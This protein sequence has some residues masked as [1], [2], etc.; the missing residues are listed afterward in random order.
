MSPSAP[1]AV[2][3]SGGPDSASSGTARGGLL[4]LLGTGVSAL[5]QLVCVLVVTRGADPANAGSL[6]AGVSVL[7]IG[8]ALAQLG[9]D[10]SLVRQVS[11]CGQRQRR[12]DAVRVTRDA[13][14]AV[15][16]L[17]LVLTASL[18]LLPSTW[19][20][21]VLG[22]ADPTA[23]ALLV[24]AVPVL[25]LHELALAV[26]RGTGSMRPTVVLERVA[27]PLL[28]VVTLSLAVTSTDD[29]R[30]LSV[31]WVLPWVAVLPASAAAAVLHLRRIPD[32]GPVAEATSRR[33]FWRFSA[34]RAV[35]RTCQVALQRADIIIV[36]ALAG[37]P[38]AAVY[39]AATRFM[40]VGQLAGT[41][42]QQAAQPFFARL[43]AAGA[44]E[45]LQ[46][47]LRRTTVWSV[48]VVWPPYLVMALAAPWLLPVFGEG[49]EAG[50]PVLTVLSVAMLLATA[51]GPVDVVLLMAGRGA[52]SLV[53]TATALAVDVVLCL[54]LVP[55]LGILGAAVAWAAAIVVRNVA[56][57][58]AVR[59]SPGLSAA[60]RDLSRVVVGA[61]VVVALPVG[62]ATGLL[63]P[64]AVLAAVVTGA[65]VLWLLLL[66]R[67]RDRLGLG[68][69][70]R[71]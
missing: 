42:V 60:S 25:A 10:V 24:L 7:L 22:S 56:S 13:V 20:A 29:P 3:R 27:R 34:T 12:A 69:L 15:L 5:A 21:R 39:T 63:A 65:A 55:H 41:A 53:I 16:A 47:L 59:R 52:T 17:G 68:G 4:N 1:A 66:W 54:L 8:A 40:V 50:A 45:D 38:A 23:S 9:T 19:T 32:G 14:V 62:M 64:P 28:Q 26:T 67:D 44:R 33:A 43:H 2:G 49:Y 57:V 48:A 71:R 37:A 58:E 31:A 18:L 30:A 46:A 61:L 36:A 6:F 35:A 51:A 70:R 11:V